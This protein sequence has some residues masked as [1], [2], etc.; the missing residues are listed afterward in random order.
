MAHHDGSP[1]LDNVN[2]V[3]VSYGPGWD[4]QN[5]TSS[6]HSLDSNGM[7]QITLSVNYDSGFSV[8]VSAIL[9]FKFEIYF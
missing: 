4:E 5:L 1:V 9:F 6:K 3:S 7:V 8:N 2:P